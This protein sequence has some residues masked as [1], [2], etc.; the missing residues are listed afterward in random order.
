MI[1]RHSQIVRFVGFYRYIWPKTERTTNPIGEKKGTG[2]L[3]NCDIP[4]NVPICRF[5]KIFE[6]TTISRITTAAILHECAAYSAHVFVFERLKRV[7]IIH[8]LHQDENTSGGACASYGVFLIIGYSI[9]MY[10][11][12]LDIVR[13]KHFQTPILTVHTKI[14]TECYFKRILSCQ[15]NI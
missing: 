3:R 11:G 14:N 9:E 8:K 5:D 13:C 2:I 6:E 4:K 7:N 10:V 12:V 1:C 15:T